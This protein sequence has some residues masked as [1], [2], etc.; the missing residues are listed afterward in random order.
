MPPD[1]LPLNTDRFGNIWYHV[2]DD[3]FCFLILGTILFAIIIQS[4]LFFR[5][6]P[7]IAGK[8]DNSYLTYSGYLFSILFLLSSNIALFWAL[9]E[10]KITL[11]INTWL[12]LRIVFQASPVL[13]YILFI[14]G[15]VENDGLI[16][17][18]NRKIF[19]YYLYGFAGLV[20]IYMA[21]AFVI[22]FQT[23]Q[24]A[25]NAYYKSYQWIT[26]L[27]GFLGIGIFITRLRGK[28]I[29]YIYVGTICIAIGAIL[30]AL[31][32]ETLD[33]NYFE[34]FP[35]LREKITLEQERNGENGARHF[36]KYLLQPFLQLGILLDVFFVSIALLQK[37]HS[38]TKNYESE[39][40]ENPYDDTNNQKRVIQIYPTDPTL[41]GSLSSQ[42]SLK[43]VVRVVHN[44]N[45]FLVYYTLD[46]D[47]VPPRQNEENPVKSSKPFTLMNGMLLGTSTE[48]ILNEIVNEWSPD[49]FFLA[50]ERANVSKSF[51]QEKLPNDC[52]PPQYGYIVS[53]KFIEE[54]NENKSRRFLAIKMLDHKI[55]LVSAGRQKEFRVWYNT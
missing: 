34:S 32:G 25:L 11:D 30:S 52:L 41:P 51:S 47:N 6:D 23:G 12:A 5:Q 40:G 8:R 43:Q 45:G 7:E 39:V 38:S 31:N 44:E 26:P 10:D 22:L 9:G 16:S 36:G 49:L 15:L 19:K 54:I 14:Y 29:V 17:I 1:Q 2:P 13:F 20:F 53:R 18:N 48:G 46:S 3:N 33:N 4:H 42:I 55:V 27:I 37:S 21:A 24:V 28:F 50:R 35:E